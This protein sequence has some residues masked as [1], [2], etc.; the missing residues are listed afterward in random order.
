VVVFTPGK[1]QFIYHGGMQLDTSGNILTLDSPYTAENLRALSWTQNGDWLFLVDGVNAPRALKRYANTSWALEVL[2]FTSTPSEWTSGNYPKCVALFEQRAYYAATPKQPQQVWASRTGL[3]EDFTMVSS[4]GTV[5]DDNAF[6]YVVFSN[7][8]NGIEWMMP[9]AALVIGTAGAEFK[10]GSTSAIDPITPKNIRIVIQTHYGSAPM[11]PAKIGSSVLFVQR[12]RNR[13]RSFEYS[14]AEDQ[15]TAT[16]ISLYA[17]QVLKGLVRE[18]RV[19]S[20]PESYCWIITEDGHLVGCTYEKSQKVLAWHM[21]ETQGHYQ[22]VCVAPTTGNDELYVAVTRSINGV[23]RTFLERFYNAWEPTDEVEECFYVDAGLTY[24]GA[25]TK[26]LVGLQHLNNEWVQVLVDGWV[27]PEV[28]VINGGITLDRAGS[29]IHVGL[30]YNSEFLSIIPQSQQKMTVGAQRRLYEAVVAVENSLDFKY[31][32]V[33]RD[34]AK[35]PKFDLA[36]N[37]P[38]KVMDKAVP[39]TS[40]HEHIQLESTPSITQQLEILQDR[41]I[42]LNIT[43]IVYG[44]SP[45]AI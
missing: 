19:Q 21:H 34:K 10:L 22:A 33:A 38:T 27:H 37:G 2:E 8:T 13:I 1:I 42:P 9:M 26:S 44:I 6:T 24:R 36:F 20:A 28:Q 23:Q 32:A 30:S 11:Y 14:Y 29:I 40:R 4:G 7:D 25:P 15:Y 12:S 41:P 16:D 39:L 5:L 3:Y 17:S 35:Q 31:R 18:L 45:A 43:G